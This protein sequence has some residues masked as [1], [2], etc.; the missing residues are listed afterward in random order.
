MEKH[1]FTGEE[2]EP[3]L[4]F[5]NGKVIKPGADYMKAQKR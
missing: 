1:V 4:N 3:L 5:E 2:G